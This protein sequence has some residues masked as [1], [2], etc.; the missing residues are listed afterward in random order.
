MAT[1]YDRVPYTNNPYP[2][3]HPSRTQ[4]VAWLFGLE[5]PPVDG[6]RV[7]ELGCGAGGNLIPMAYALPGARFVGVDSS[8][9]QIDDARA[10]VAALGLVNV[11]FRAASVAD[12]T[13]DLGSFDYVVAH[14]LYSWVPPAAQGHVLRVCRENLAPAGV[15]Y[16][17]FNTYPGWHQKRW[18]RD[19]MLYHASQFAGDAQKV[20]QARAF[21]EAVAG[22][23][24][25]VGGPFG[26]ALRAD[27]AEL[28]GRPDTYVLHEYLEEHNEPLYFSEFVKR[29]AGGGLQYLADAQVNGTVIE[30]QQPEARQVLAPLAG[31]LLRTEQYADFFRNRSFRR[32]LLCHA[33][34][35]LDRAFPAGRVPALSVAA[36]LRPPPGGWP[37]EAGSGVRFTTARNHQVTIADPQA[38]AAMDVI[39][40]AYPAAVSFE[41]VEAE[42]GATGDARNRLAGV[43]LQS[44]VLNIADLYRRPHA[45]EPR[46][47]DRPRA[48][49]LARYQA[50]RDEASP[51]EG[52]TN[53]R[54]EW[55]RLDPGPRHLL[56]AAN[57]T[58]T[59]EDIASQALAAGRPPAGTTL[60][61]AVDWARRG[62]EELARLALLE[63]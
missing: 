60:A 2:E 63:S 44:W 20:Q 33:G 21:A 57:G 8:A 37:T 52:V 25:V 22:S 3:S 7:L 30:E 23:P 14:G 12:L 50:S 26:E 15:A 45:F 24:A 6:C 39:G 28:R 36:A 56:A 34:L 9:R 10:V 32:A 29:A 16:V 43:V 13:P 47:T 31:D 27:V 40:R 53:L 51:G 1:S 17:S 35:T 38:K 55:V 58:R 54:H 11:E 18:L 46:V 61:G 41:Q 62:L 59:L 19:A 48:S 49:A 4:A 5:S 42:L